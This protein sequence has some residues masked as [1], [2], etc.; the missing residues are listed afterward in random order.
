MHKNCTLEEMLQDGF[1]RKFAQFYMSILESENQN[2]VFDP[3]YVHWAHERGFTAECASVLNLTD[4]NINNYL[5]QYDF[6]KVWPLNNWAR[7]WV[8]DKLTLKYT[9]SSD[10]LKC[11]LPKYYYYTTQHGLRT[12]MIRVNRA[13][14]NA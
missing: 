11:Y 10:R 9:L 7:L 8:N 6:N 3:E 1:T 2:T 12:V 4:D 14:L 13:F 5:S